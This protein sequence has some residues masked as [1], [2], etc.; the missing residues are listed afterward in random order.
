MNTTL[1]RAEG[2]LL[3]DVTVLSVKGQKRFAHMC[4]A[5]VEHIYV[6]SFHDDYRVTECNV[7]LDSY[8]A[9]RI[10][11]DTMDDFYGR[12]ARAVE[13]ALFMEVFGSPL[14][15]E[16]ANRAHKAAH[17]AATASAWASSFAITGV[18]DPQRLLC[19]SRFAI[20]ASDD[21]AA[22]LAW[23]MQTIET[24]LSDDENRGGGSERYRSFPSSFL[25]AW[26]VPTSSSGVI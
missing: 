23:Q 13:D 24:L 3:K 10:N 8:L 5:H 18:G 4:A 26:Y 21:A 6:E 16:E 7:A 14:E 19:I 22:E 20:S 2:L 25:T 9:R 11:A 17:R 12:A 1:D 15:D